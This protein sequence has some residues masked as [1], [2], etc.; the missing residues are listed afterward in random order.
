MEFVTSAIV[1]GIILLSIA[2]FV[3]RFFLFPVRPGPEQPTALDR[4]CRYCGKPGGFP[5]PQMML[6][7]PMADWMYRR[8]GVV[9][10]R[11]WRV[12]VNPGVEAPTHLCEVHQEMAR[13]HLERRL[14]ESHVEYA[15][16]CE[17]QILDMHDFAESGLDALMK[18]NAKRD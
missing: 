11:R 4:A 12:E 3:W 17:K 2:V 6:V 9:P 15:A 18:K 5:V 13:G 14:A 7:R 8:L 1:V 10:L 16:F